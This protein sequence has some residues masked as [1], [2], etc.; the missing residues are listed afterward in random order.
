ME[1][2]KEDKETVE[3]TDLA[4]VSALGLQLGGRVVL[5]EVVGRIR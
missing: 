2:M 3:L 1:R 4:C 5:H